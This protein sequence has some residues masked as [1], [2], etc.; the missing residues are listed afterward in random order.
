MSATTTA[1]DVE[2]DYL[3]DHHIERSFDASPLLA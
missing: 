1:G 2:P 3:A